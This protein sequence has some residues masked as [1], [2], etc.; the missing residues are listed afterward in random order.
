MS[1]LR[2]EMFEITD[3]MTA[4]DCMR[5]IRERQ[6]EKAKWK[7]FYEGR[8]QAVNETCDMDI[9][10]LTM[11]LMG[12]FQMVPHKVTKTQENYALPSGKLALKK[13]EPEFHRDDNELIEWL[14]KNGGEKYIKVKESVDW[15]ALKGT[16]NV[17]GD[18]VADVNGN[19]IPCI[20]AEERPDVF[21]V[22]LKKEGKN[23]QGTVAED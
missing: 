5:M 1:E 11:A 7:E 20:T 18:T 8:I 10:R 16:L 9:A 2:E 4:E 19:V 21:K 12:Y 15:S 17:M 6:E 23:V 22:E 13:Q 3:D 14:K